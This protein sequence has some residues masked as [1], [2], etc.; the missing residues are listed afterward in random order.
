MKLNLD[1]FWMIF[2]CLADKTADPAGLHDLNHSSIVLSSRCE[3]AVS[4]YVC[5]NATL[6]LWVEAALHYAINKRERGVNK[7]LPLLN[8]THREVGNESTDS[9]A[10]SGPILKLHE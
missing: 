8:R 6:H 2:H 9:R 5:A 7:S 3:I 10:Q 1:F 4:R